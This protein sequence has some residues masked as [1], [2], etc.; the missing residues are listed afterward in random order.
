M[1]SQEIVLT[2]IKCCLKNPLK[3]ALFGKFM[4]HMLSKIVTTN[5]RHDNHHKKETIIIN[6]QWFRCDGKWPVNV[7]MTVEMCSS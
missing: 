2:R 7:A 5:Q 1:I 4:V 6:K 3:I